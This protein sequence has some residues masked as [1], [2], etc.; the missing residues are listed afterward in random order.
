MTRR[1]ARKR[2]LE[3][4]FEMDLG[5]V[6]PEDVLSKSP[7]GRVAARGEEVF[8]SQAIKG[9]LDNLPEIDAFIDSFSPEWPLHRMGAADRNV[10]RIA[11]YE[12]LYREDIPVAV[13][14]NEAVVLA[15]RFGGEGSG[16][17]VNGVLGAVS[18][19]ALVKR[20]AQ[21]GTGAAVSDSEQPLSHSNQVSNLI[22]EVKGTQG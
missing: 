14:I 4:L 21:P 12:L 10:L 11:C 1:Q 22:T 5:K 16:K 20:T 15:K 9:I 7:G 18:R 19:G 3:L 2:V 17:F 13:S 6:S 8:I